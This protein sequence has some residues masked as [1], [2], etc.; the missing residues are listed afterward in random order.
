MFHRSAIPVVLGMVLGGVLL[1]PAQVSINLGETKSGNL[2]ASS[3]RSVGCSS[4][5][6]DLY[7]LTVPSGSPQ[8]VYITMTSSAFDT[9]LRVLDSSGKA[10]FANNDDKRTSTTTT[11]SF[12]GAL[13]NPGTYRIEATSYD[14]SQ[15]GAYTLAVRGTAANI[16]TI[17]LG[18]SVS[19]NLSSSSGR[20][21]LGDGSSADL[22]EFSVA[23]QQVVTI[24][25]R[26]V[27][28]DAY[29]VLMDSSG[30]YLASDDDSGGGTD[31]QIVRTLAPGKYRAEAGT[32]VGQGGAYTLSLQATNPTVTTITAGQTVNGTL[33]STSG[34]SGGCAGCYADLYQFT[35][36]SSQTLSVAMNSTVFDTYLR[37]LDGSGNMLAADDDSGGGTNS[38]VQRAFAA[39]TYRIEAT[40]YSSGIGG[41]YTLALSAVTAQVL[42]ISVGQTLSGSLTAS[43]GRSVGCSGCFADLYQFSVTSSQTLNIVLT[44][45]AFDA[46][47]RVLD[48][49]GSTVATDDDGAGGSNARIYR[50]FAAGTYRIE[51]TSYNSGKTGAY[52]LALNTVNVT[53]SPITVGTAATTVN[54]SLSASSGS[55]VACT[56]CFANSYGFTLSSAQ[57]VQI[58]LT[59]TAFDAY[60]RVLDA[61]GVVV[62]ADDDS[63]GGSN[64]RIR[65]SFAAGTYRIEASSYS[66]GATGAFT[67]VVQVVS[68]TVA[69]IA[70][71]Q[72]VNGTLSA[73][74]GRSAGCAG[75]YADLY[76]F[77]VSSA[78]PLIIGLNSTAFDA[79]LRVLDAGGATVDTD[80]DSGGGTNARISRTF[81]AGTY[82]VE[83]TSYSSAKAGAYTLSVATPP[84]GVP[85][86]V[87]MLITSLSPSSAQAG[88]AAFTLLVTGSGFVS[89][90]VVQWAGSDRSTTVVSATQLQ[91]AILAGDLAGSARTVLVTARSGTA[92]SNSLSFTITS[93]APTLTV[94]PE[95]LNFSAL[96]NQASPAAQNLAVAGNVGWTASVR[97]SAGGN[98]LTV[99]PASGTAP[100]TARVNVS[101]TGVAAGVYTGLITVQS[102]TGGLLQVVAATLVITKALPI[103]QPS[104]TGFLFQGI[105]GQSIPALTFQMMNVGSGT[106]NWQI[107]AQTPDGRNWL[108]VSPAGG[109]TGA[110]SGATAPTAT[111][112]VDSTLLKAGVSVGLLTFEAQGAPNSPQAGLVLVS[113]LPPGSDP[114][115]LVQPAGFVF[116]GIT[117]GAAPAGKDLV[118]SASGGASIQFAA[119]A[120]TAGGGNWLTVTPASGSVEGGRTTLRVRA[121]SGSLARGVYTGTI[122]VT[123]GTG[124]RQDL[125]VV[126]VLSETGGVAPQG[127]G[128]P[129]A[130]AACT[131]SRL[132]LVETMLAGNFTLSVSWPVSLR[133]LVFN[134]C[135]QPVTDA[136]VIASFNT[137]DPPVVLTS[138]KDGNY[139][140]NWIPGKSDRT[141][142]TIRARATGLAEAVTQIDGKVGAGGGTLP[143]VSRN[144]TLNAASYQKYVPVAPGTLVSVFGANLGT[145]TAS[146]STTPLPTSLADVR[147]QLGGKD[148]GLVFANGG[149]VNAQVPTDLVPGTTASLVVTVRGVAAA[150]DQITL[151][152]AQ[153]GIFSLNSAGTGQGAIQ[154]SN[155]PIYAAPQ[156]SVP[157]SQARPADRGEYIT[158]YCTGLGATDP[159][160]ASGMAAPSSPLATVKTAVTVSIGGIQ[161]PAAFAGLS[162]G[163][164]GLYQV[165]IQVPSG[166][167][168]GDA[169]PLVMTQAGVNSNTVT[170]AVR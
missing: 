20:T 80:D 143:Q 158:I 167:Q 165:N 107:R 35:L 25:M 32:F 102:T 116:V 88:G 47:L 6:A 49:A 111:V 57:T 61:N 162:P 42:P 144:A 81:A 37:V 115:I 3:G 26:S 130:Q 125:S 91:A 169:V 99:A 103:L 64:S 95:F 93:S 121:D 139:T 76:Q 82:R 131:P 110:G 14:P 126:L 75:C 74:S 71:G 41:A 54:G 100:T 29:M 17:S 69:Q 112:R 23:S 1:A 21:V 148:M 18:Q 113:M 50:T 86:P 128:P 72:T 120:S 170:V 124:V 16:G 67:L 79:Y 119:A 122:T 9:F 114:V 164:V 137:G 19:G 133:T 157:G 123:L 46:F 44:S 155:T 161:V 58:D 98:W 84:S 22:Y 7:Q 109:S 34:R 136:T 70:V 8:V 101:S 149:Q 134:D 45:S 36:T 65:R 85:A 129:V 10:L 89:G 104:Q 154:V 145:S 138:L 15:A 43:S 127:V 24:T 28:M 33:S 118:V 97:T 66:T 117:G 87:L 12:I 108:S 168:P 153:P 53:V 11:N 159:P 140:G 59:S 106:M 55:S 38:L 105:E 142:V 40:S 94:S 78:Q 166:V 83:A 56:G 150:P 51:A 146:A 73:T 52:T 27:A 63:G 60:L 160:V 132:T 5:Y 39:G 4:C 96:E 13:L 156:G 135:G 31:S 152:D 90:S 147:A 48:S 2:S 68:V 77:T 92:V 163:F 62:A 141:T 30:L 151:A